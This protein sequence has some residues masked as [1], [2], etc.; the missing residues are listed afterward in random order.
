FLDSSVELGDN[1]RIELKNSPVKE[2]ICLEA[3]NKSLRKQNKK[4]KEE[5][6][7]QIKKLKSQII[8]LKEKTEI[9][10]QDIKEMIEEMKEKIKN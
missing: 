6:Q 1:A 8:D 10:N 5:F 3:E 7:N 2:R 9:Q 4:I